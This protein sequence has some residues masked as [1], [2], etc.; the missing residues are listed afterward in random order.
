MKSS[1]HASLVFLDICLFLSFK[2]C[3]WEKKKKRMKMPLIQLTKSQHIKTIRENKRASW[4]RHQFAAFPQA[5][6][7]LLTWNIILLPEMRKKKPF[8]MYHD[9]NPT[10]FLFKLLSAVIFKA[11]SLSPAFYHLNSLVTTKTVNTEFSCMMITD[12]HLHLHWH[13]IIK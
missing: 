3:W 9:P 11:Y 7:Q 5:L 8:S 10:P 13:V 2:C 4:Q 6:C 12:F 1:N